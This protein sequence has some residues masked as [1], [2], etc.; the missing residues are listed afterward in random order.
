VLLEQ[1]TIQWAIYKEQKFVTSGCWKVQIKGLAVSM[2][3]EGLVLADG[4]F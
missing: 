3:G 2:S 4:I 1:N